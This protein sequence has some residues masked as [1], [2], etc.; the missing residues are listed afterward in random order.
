VGWWAG[1]RQERRWNISPRCHRA[2][3]RDISGVLY[4]ESHT[5]KNDIDYSFI[6]ILLWF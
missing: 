4:I 2:R 1:W 3:L 5:K 6:G